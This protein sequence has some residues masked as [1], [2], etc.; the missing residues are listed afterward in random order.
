VTNFLIS[1]VSLVFVVGAV[2]ERLENGEASVGLTA[3]AIFG[4][5]WLF[6]EIAY[7]KCNTKR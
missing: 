4:I 2:K 5:L 3:G 7:Y 1:M 6:S